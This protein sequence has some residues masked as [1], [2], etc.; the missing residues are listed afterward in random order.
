MKKFESSFV[1][2]RKETAAQWEECCSKE[3]FLERL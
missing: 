3:K 1:L 2:G